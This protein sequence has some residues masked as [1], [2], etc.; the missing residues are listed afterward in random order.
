MKYF[1]ILVGTL[2]LPAS[3]IMNAMN[4]DDFDVAFVLA[5]S[6]VLLWAGKNNIY[7]ENY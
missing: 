5:S 3:L 2:L 4:K 1:F 7:E 6:F